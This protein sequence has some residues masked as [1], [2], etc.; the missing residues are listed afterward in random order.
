MGAESSTQAC[1]RGKNRVD[2]HCNLQV[3][4]NLLSIV[5]IQPSFEY[6]KLKQKIWE[7]NKAE[8]E[9]FALKYSFGTWYHG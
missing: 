4:L 7:H 5:N 1:A 3:E 6:G 8:Q 2:N 9:E